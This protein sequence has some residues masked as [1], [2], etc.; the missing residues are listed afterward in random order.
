MRSRAQCVDGHHCGRYPAAPFWQNATGGDLGLRIRSLAPRFCSRTER[1]LAYMIWRSRTDAGAS[2]NAFQRKSAGTGATKSATSK[3]ASEGSGPAKP[4]GPNAGGSFTTDGTLRITSTGPGP[5]VSV[6]IGAHYPP[7]CRCRRHR[8]LTSG[9]RRRPTIARSR[10]P[11]P[12]AG[13][14]PPGTRQRP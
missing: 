11:K 10:S 1:Q 6:R 14:R 2:K 5:A 3:G 9:P 13:W 4:V 12:P 8:R 7:V